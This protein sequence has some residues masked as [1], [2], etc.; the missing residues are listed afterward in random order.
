MGR[1]GQVMLFVILAIFIVVVAF[2]FFIVRSDR[3][4]D[5]D[6]FDASN[7]KIF[8]DDCIERVGNYVVLNIS[9]GGG[10]Y[11]LS[12]IST[13][14]GVSIYYNEGR[15]T[16]PLL[17]DIEKEI[18]FFVAENLFLCTRNF[19]DFPEYKIGQGR[20][21]VD[22]EIL[23]DKVVLNVVYPIRVRK[24]DSVIVYNDFGNFDFFYRLKDFYDLSIEY[25]GMSSN[26]GVC[27]NC[28][29]EMAEKYDVKISVFDIE[30]LVFILK[31]NRN[32]KF[33]YM[34]GVRV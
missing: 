11:F 27:L 23:S 4:V 8:I 2:L 34:F 26:K 15:E 6:S 21:L 20:I 32:E 33:R 17:D 31:D 9:R 12:N 25:L 1:K 22:S 29:E 10:Y 13:K 14:S 30:D 19:T 24:G 18:D 7:V 16:Y 3:D 28:L 5:K